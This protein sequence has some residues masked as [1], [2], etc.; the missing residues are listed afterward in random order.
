MKP[1]LIVL[2]LCASLFTAVQ[3]QGAK[4][5]LPKACGDDNVRFDVSTQKGQPP[6]AA[7]E[8]G[9]AQL[10]FIET[11]EKGGYTCIGH[12]PEFVTRV[13]LN[14]AWIGAN[15][16]NSFFAYTVDPGEYH[17][18]VDWQ[19]ARGKLRRKVGMDA[20]ILDPGTV[21][22]YQVKVKSIMMSDTYSELDLK[23]VA[24]SQDEANYLFPLSALSI[25][26]PKK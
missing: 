1:R 21:Y 8:A 9:K 20:F 19:S 15:K 5:I 22:Y 25:S 16:G 14:G 12:C 10:V 13:G 17:L 6:P 4:V 18:C 23:L 7:P 11:M 26:K 2:F 3:A 24:L